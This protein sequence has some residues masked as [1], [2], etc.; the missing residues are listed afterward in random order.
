MPVVIAM[1]KGIRFPNAL[2]IKEEY[3]LMHCVHLA[4][5]SCWTCVFGVYQDLAVKIIVILY[6]L[7]MIQVYLA[8]RFWF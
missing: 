3:C 5:V 7:E 6:V 4:F 1:K 8:I 2:M